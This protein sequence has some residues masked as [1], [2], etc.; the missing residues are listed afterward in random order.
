MAQTKVKLE[1][2]TGGFNTGTEYFV[3]P[4]CKITA[5]S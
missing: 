3:V 2:L 1:L 4:S 5:Y